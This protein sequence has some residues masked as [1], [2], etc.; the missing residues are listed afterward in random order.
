MSHENTLEM[1]QAIQPE[2]I[3]RCALCGNEDKLSPV[4]KTHH[5]CGKCLSALERKWNTSS[6]TGFERHAFN[7]ELQLKP[8]LSVKYLLGVIG[9][10]ADFSLPHLEAICQNPALL[11][12][13]DYERIFK[14]LHNNKAFLN[15]KFID[16]HDVNIRLEA[17]A[18]LCKLETRRVRRFYSFPRNS[19]IRPYELNQLCHYLRLQ[20]WD[21]L[22]WQKSQRKINAE[23]LNEER[24][25]LIPT[26]NRKID[27]LG[28]IRIPDKILSV[29]NLEAKSQVA[30]TVNI[31][32][33]YIIL[34]PIKG[35]CSERCVC[36][37][38]N[39]GRVAIPKAIRK[40]FEIKDGDSWFTI[41]VANS[42]QI[43]LYK[44]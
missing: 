35:E 13:E 37:I 28:R 4:N 43:F 17:L 5:I 9:A 20:P 39:L 11:T 42:R 3:P 12:S 41:V 7:L 18:S 34:T 10:W 27:T 36:N 14:A 44:R 33:G 40:L 38:D 1:V 19:D 30:L 29:L 26:L 8:Y 32:K 6:K 24:M 23:E 22:K 2:K 31:E 21:L 25:N 15:P 16:W